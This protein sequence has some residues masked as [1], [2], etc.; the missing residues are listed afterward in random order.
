MN[1]KNRIAVFKPEDYCPICGK[2]N[3]SG[4]C[5]RSVYAGIDAA[6]TRA[7]YEEQ[8]ESYCSPFGKTP[9][10]QT[11]LKEGFEMLSDDEVVKRY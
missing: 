7:T 8:D 11:R 4:N 1:N 5:A 6:N 10:L 2:R 3:H 9:N